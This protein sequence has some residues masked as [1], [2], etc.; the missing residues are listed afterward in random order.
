MQLRPQLYA[1][2]IVGLALQSTVAIA[3]RDRLGFACVVAMFFDDLELAGLLPG[4]PLGLLWSCG[5]GDR[6][7]RLLERALG[8]CRRLALS[9]EFALGAVSLNLRK[10]LSLLQR[11]P[12]AQRRVERTG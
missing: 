12:L 3:V 11:H 9:C 10:R 1:T 2:E 8:R 4:L 5:H 6:G 7:P